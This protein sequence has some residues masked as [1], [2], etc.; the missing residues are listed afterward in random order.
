MRLRLPGHKKGHSGDGLVTEKRDRA[1]GRR[2]K[3]LNAVG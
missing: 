3:E 1:M 2:G